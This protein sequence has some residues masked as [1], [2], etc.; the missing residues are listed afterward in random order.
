MIVSTVIVSPDEDI[1]ILAGVKNF[2]HPQRHTTAVKTVNIRFIV[3]EFIES[4]T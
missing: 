4:N 1:V 2:S 3:N